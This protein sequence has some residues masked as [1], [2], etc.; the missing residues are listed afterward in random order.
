MENGRISFAV[1]DKTCLLKFKGSIDFHIS[2][3]FDKFLQKLST[4]SD[5]ESFVIDLTEAAHIDST[6]LGLLARLRDISPGQSAVPPTLI[7]NNENINEVLYNVGFSRIFNIIEHV[8][9]DFMHLENVSHMES[10]PD[11]LA[12]I[13]LKA[14]TE[15]VKLSESNKELFKDV[16]EYLEKDTDGSTSF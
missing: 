7:S 5:I 8:D 4:R 11:N 14:H 1:I 9:T 16:I 13:M 2:P 15:L 10:S 12:I 3:D 6:N